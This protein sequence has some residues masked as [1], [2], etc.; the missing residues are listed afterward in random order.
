MFVL[1]ECR[2][3]TF[4]CFMSY[5]EKQQHPEVFIL[6]RSLVCECSPLSLVVSLLLLHTSQAVGCVCTL[7]SPP[8]LTGDHGMTELCCVYRAFFIAAGCTSPL[9]WWEGMLLPSIMNMKCSTKSALQSV[10]SLRLMLIAS[11][12]INNV[13]FVVPINLPVTHSCLVYFPSYLY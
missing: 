6:P 8:L 13:L 1:F 4:P 3:G 12:T 5:K 11:S 7:I 2:V 10:V 9:T